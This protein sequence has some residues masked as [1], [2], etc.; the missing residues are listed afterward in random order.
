[1]APSSRVNRDAIPGT[2]HLVD[3]DG[4]SH[5][6]H[7]KGHRDII[8]VPAPSK[9]PDDP[10]NW[11]PRRKLLSTFCNFTWIFL[12]FPS[13]IDSLA[14]CWKVSRYVMTCGIST[15]TIYSVIVPIS[16]ATGLDL[17][18]LNSGTGYV[19]CPTKFFSYF[20][21][22]LILLYTLPDAD[23]SYRCFFC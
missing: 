20:T 19:C 3:V 2:V 16:D 7:S 5:A 1:M 21:P 4:T 14:R 9:N 17:G 12:P 23:C 6:M 18:T 15:A 10:L 22:P 11:T 8:L 13:M